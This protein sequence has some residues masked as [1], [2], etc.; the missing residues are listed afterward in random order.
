M[1]ERVP[2]TRTDADGTVI[3]GTAQIDRTDR[4]V[5][6]TDFRDLD[7]RPLNLPPGSRFDYRLALPAEPEWAEAVGRSPDGNV[8]EL[9]ADVNGAPAPRLRDILMVP[10][11]L[12]CHIRGER[13]SLHDPPGRPHSEWLAEHLGLDAKSRALAAQRRRVWALLGLLALIGAILIGT[14][15]LLASWEVYFGASAVMLAG[16][17]YLSTAIGYWVRLYR[18]TRSKADT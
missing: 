10:G 4:A 11:C 18:A 5:S 1:A 13:C 14:G 9:D 16:F 15:M 2:I 17:V 7:G 12:T 8:V 6:I 3:D